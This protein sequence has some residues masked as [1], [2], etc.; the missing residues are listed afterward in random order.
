M[1]PFWSQALQRIAGL[2]DHAHGSIAVPER[3]DLHPVARHPSFR[4]FAA[5]NPAT[6]AGKRDLPPALRNRFTEVWVGEPTQ[7]EDLAAIAS[8]YLANSSSAGGVDNIV[9][10][11]VAAKEA[12]DHILQ[13]SAGQ[14]PVY[15]LRTLCRALEYA[16][17]ATPMYGIRR[18]FYDGI[19]MSFLTHLDPASGTHLEQLMRAHL[20]GTTTIQV[21]NQLSLKPLLVV[22]NPIFH[23]YTAHS[24]PLAVF[25]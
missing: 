19:S 1:L 18:A 7:L 6:D 5:M 20:L 2:L 23:S 13:D 8:G 16:A 3:G 10:F 4:L 17:Y 21:W 12:A 22:Y 24:S 14:R 11:Y 15:N 9:K 25:V